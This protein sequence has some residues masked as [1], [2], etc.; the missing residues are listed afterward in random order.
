[1]ETVDNI[2]SNIVESTGK[3]VSNKV[4]EKISNTIPD[5]LTN[6]LKIY[7]KNTSVKDMA[8]RTAILSAS[9]NIKLEI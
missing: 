5:R 1:M 6:L 7:F 8:K 9:L 3:A 4:E 2:K